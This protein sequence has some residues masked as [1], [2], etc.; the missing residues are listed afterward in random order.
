MFNIVL[1]NLTCWLDQLLSPFST[2]LTFGIFFRTTSNTLRL[3]LSISTGDTGGKLPVDLSG[4][5]F[6]LYVAII[7]FTI[8]FKFWCEIYKHTKV[9]IKMWAA[10]RPQSP[11]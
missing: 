4:F 3:T 7:N 10:G 6:F 1:N 8:V 5:G 9:T 2:L 11:P